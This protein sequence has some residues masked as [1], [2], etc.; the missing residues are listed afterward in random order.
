MTETVPCAWCKEPFERTNPRRL[1]C[2]DTCRQ[3]KSKATRGM[4]PKHNGNIGN[5]IG[6]DIPNHGTWQ[7]Y[8]QIKCRCGSCT[9]AEMAYRKWLKNTAEERGAEDPRICEHCTTRFPTK[10]AKW[11]HVRLEHPF[12]KGPV[13]IGTTPNVFDLPSLDMRSW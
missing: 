5:P 9:S 13:T 10:K 12:T 3:Q 2:S 11:D 6:G 1:T 4:E 8:R 7:R